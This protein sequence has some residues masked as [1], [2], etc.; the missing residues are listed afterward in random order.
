[1]GVGCI[2]REI[3]ESGKG[4]RRRE[5]GE[6]SGRETNRMLSMERV[7]LFVLGL[8]LPCVLPSVEVEE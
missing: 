3:T 4:R 5:E 7:L 2:E 6:E 8:L 1:L